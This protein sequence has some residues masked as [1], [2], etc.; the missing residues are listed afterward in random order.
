M[1]GSLGV[2]VEILGGNWGMFGR[3]SAQ[4][5]SL[6]QERNHGAFEFVGETAFLTG[7]ASEIGGSAGLAWLWTGFAR[8]GQPGLALIADAVTK[9]GATRVSAGRVASARLS[10]HGQRIL[11]P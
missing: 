4:L 11:A 10:D 3:V 5:S 6:S 1:Q 8:P 2:D 7:A 9:R